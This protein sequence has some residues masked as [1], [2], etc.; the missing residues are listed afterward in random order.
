M[1]YITIILI[2]I[3]CMLFYKYLIWNFNYWKKLGVPGP[4]PKPFFGSFP[5]ATMQ[6]KQVLYEIDE[7]YK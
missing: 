4:K 5:G 7:I 6:S 2:L 1:F 3:L